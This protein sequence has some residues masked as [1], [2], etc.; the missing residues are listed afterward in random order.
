MSKCVTDAQDA[1][2]IILKSCWHA[3]IKSFPAIDGILTEF[4]NLYNTLAHQ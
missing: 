1:L 2:W 3:I 4:S